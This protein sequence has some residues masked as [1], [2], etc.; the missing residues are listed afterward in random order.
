M[1]GQGFWSLGMER[2]SL[3]GDPG[4]WGQWLVA[5]TGHCR[6]PLGSHRLRL[7]LWAGDGTAL[8]LHGLSGVRQRVGPAEPWRPRAAQQLL[9]EADTAGDG[10]DQ[11]RGHPARPAAHPGPHQQHRYEP[12][13]RRW[14][15]TQLPGT[16][17]CGQH[18]RPKPP[19]ASP[20]WAAHLQ[21]LVPTALSRVTP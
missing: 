20:L 16:P 21:A 4:G 7:G 6:V 14:D 10:P 5:V 12:L 13:A 17:A 3:G 1:P 9:I 11:A 2:Q 15:P 19:R 18:G 8:G